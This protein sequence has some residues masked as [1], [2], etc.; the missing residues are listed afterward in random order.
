MEYDNN[1]R[2]ALF[3]ND[4]GDNPKRPDYT[5]KG[6]VDGVEKRLAAWIKTSKSGQT[7]MSIEFTDDDY[8][9]NVSQPR[10]AAPQVSQQTEED[11][12]F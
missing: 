12:P 1:N 9:K 11:V 5:G 3:K 8:N 2:A 6:M 4:K 10:Q 7:Y